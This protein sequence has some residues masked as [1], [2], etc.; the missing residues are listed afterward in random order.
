MAKYNLSDNQK[1]VIKKIYSTIKKNKPNSN[2]V[3]YIESKMSGVTKSIKIGNDTYNITE[4]KIFII[5]DYLNSQ[6]HIVDETVGNYKNVN[7][8]SLMKTF[9]SIPTISE[10]KQELKEEISQKSDKKREKIIDLEFKILD[11]ENKIRDNI[12]DNILDDYYKYLEQKTNTEKKKETISMVTS[13]CNNSLKIYNHFSEKDMSN[14]SYNKNR[15][16]K[17]LTDKSSKNDFVKFL[18]DKSISAYE[19]KNYKVSSELHKMTMSMRDNEYQSLE[20]EERFRRHKDFSAKDAKELKDRWASYHQNKN[21][22]IAKSQWRK[23]LKNSYNTVKSFEK[24][25]NN[26]YNGNV[27][28]EIKTNMYYQEI[29]YYSE[30]N[31]E[32]LT[33]SRDKYG[34]EEYEYEITNTPKGAVPVADVKYN[35]NPLFLNSKLKAEFNKVR[36]SRLG[37]KKLEADIKILNKDIEKDRSLSMGM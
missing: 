19:D 14:T 22:H 25:I 12:L 32:Y 4:Q 26:K 7:K 28:K 30:E 15:I 20:V 3:T 13:I 33:I 8:A 31:C 18:T 2:T 1:N 5:K 27:L 24:E 29:D 16:D 36:N 9:N 11:E 35:V 34:N 37:I 6:K 17:F 10:L 21:K 23:Y